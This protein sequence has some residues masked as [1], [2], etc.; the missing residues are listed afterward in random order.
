MLGVFNRRSKSEGK[1]NRYWRSSGSRSD[2]KWLR[3]PINYDF[4]DTKLN[5][6]DHFRPLLPSSCSPLAAEQ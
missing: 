2:K 4:F 1:P 6:V 5:K 3:Q